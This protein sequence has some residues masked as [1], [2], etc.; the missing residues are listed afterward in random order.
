MPLCGPL[1]SRVLRGWL[2]WRA[3]RATAGRFVDVKCG[4]DRATPMPAHMKR[5]TPSRL[6]VDP[7]ARDAFDGDDF[8][9][10][11]DLPAPRRWNRG[12]WSEWTGDTW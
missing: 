8:G 3:S 4:A 2:W 11:R 12:D 9:H 1:D 6:C 10:L 7:G 5:P